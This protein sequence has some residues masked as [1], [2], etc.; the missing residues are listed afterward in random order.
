M[1]RGPGAEKN[2]YKPQILWDVI[3]YPC[4]WY[5]LLALESSWCACH[6]LCSMRWWKRRTGIVSKGMIIVEVS[7]HLQYQSKPLLSFIWLYG[8]FDFNGTCCLPTIAGIMLL[9][10]RHCQ[11][12]STDLKIGYP[13]TGTLSSNQLQK[14][15]ACHCNWF[16]VPVDLRMS[17]RDLTTWI[18]PS[19]VVPTMATRATCPIIDGSNKALLLKLSLCPD[20]F[21]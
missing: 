2:T 3:T 1:N 14:L 12:T 17:C 6:M 19:P 7:N 11:A 8:L 9:S 16:E 5:L 13:S 18:Y 21:V 15:V 10:S 4:P 20:A